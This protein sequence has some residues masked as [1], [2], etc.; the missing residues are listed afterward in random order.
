MGEHVKKYQDLYSELSG[1]EKKGVYIYINGAPA[2][3][4]QVVNA[5]IMREDEVYMRDYVL[6]EKG[7]IKELCFHHVGPRK[8]TQY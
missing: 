6:N 7:D 4:L 2:S 1:Y 3:P 5:H 8:K